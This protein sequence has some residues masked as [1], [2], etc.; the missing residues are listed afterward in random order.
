MY[1]QF[2]NIPTYDYQ[3][4]VWSKTSFDSQEEFGEFL[5]SIFKDVGEYEFDKSVEEWNITGRF[6]EE[7]ST[8]T[9][10]PEGS[11]DFKDF[12][13]FERKKNRLGVIYKNDDKTWYVPRDYYFLINYCPISNK[14]KANRTSLCDIRDVQ[15]HISLYTKMADVL[16][17][18]P[19]I[20]KKRQIMSSYMHAAKLLNI[21]WFEQSANLKLIASSD[22][23]ISNTGGTWKILNSYR[24]FL[25]KNTYWYRAN[26]PDKT[27]NWQQ[28]LKIKEG[29]REY[30]SGNMS[31]LTGIVVKNDPAAGV[32]GN[33]YYIFCEE[34]GVFPKLT[35]SFQFAE[36]SLKAGAMTT[37]SFIA[38][39][40]V[41]DLKQCEG[42]KQIFEDPESYGFLGVPCKWI[43][44]EGDVGIRGLFIPEQFGRKPFVDKYGNSLIKEALQ[45]MDEEEKKKEQ[46]SQKDVRLFK[47]Q[48]PRYV[49]DAF[50]YREESYFQTE[51]IVKKQDRI[52]IDKFSK[53]KNIKTFEDGE[54]NIKW[55]FAENATPI[56]TSD[57]NEILKLTDK[58]GCVQMFEPPIKDKPNKFTY[59][60]GVDPVATDITS[61]SESLCACYIWKTMIEKRELQEDGTVKTSIEGYK[62]VAWYVGRY[63]TLEAT[64]YEVEKLVRLYNAHTLCENNVTSWID[65]MKK[66][67]LRQHL[68]GKDEL[69]FTKDIM[70]NSTV[71]REF[72]VYMG[73]GEGKL[74]Q[75]LLS[76]GKEYIGEL[77][78]SIKKTDGEVVRNIWG[79]DRIEDFGV[80]DEFKNFRKGL[81]VDRMIAFLLGLSI[82]RNYIQMG[83]YKKETV[84]SEKEQIVNP[85]LRKN[86]SYFSKPIQ[87]SYKKNISYFKH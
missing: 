16:H 20:L 13:D 37:G 63:D 80:L 19:V 14:E 24:D 34:A 18:H 32:G 27:Y 21:Y 73:S 77:L 67:N 51:L 28:K 31:T 65:H 43:N 44:K 76:I 61:S 30:F 7:N 84:Q 58:I 46:T 17:K 42:L 22:N 78:D 1:V 86:L 45:N 3:T 8:Y 15:Y 29:G 49:S 11:K 47:S 39:G 25:N 71:N 74:K 38:A 41:G 60:A 64:N 36:P 66:K 57:K 75:Y 69:A 9:L 48:H 85:V 10:A 55:K 87:G 81:N 33:N 4:K 26:S 6:Y 72:G 12:W 40:S 56:L 54:G 68:A 79:V 53:I 82:T 35:E 70:A 50:D 23:Y 83:V 62:P 2:R 52:K 59:F 5:L